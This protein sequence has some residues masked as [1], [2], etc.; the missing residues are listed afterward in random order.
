MGEAPAE[1]REEIARTRVRMGATID[2]L[3][4]KADVKDRAR[5]WF[6]L[7]VAAIRARAHAMLASLSSAVRAR[8][9]ALRG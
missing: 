3:A 7:R 6:W 9:G 2:A 8:R 4:A 5:G 1:I